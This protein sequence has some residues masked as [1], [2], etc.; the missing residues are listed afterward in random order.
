[1]RRLALGVGA[2]VLAPACG[3]DDYGGVPGASGTQI[4]WDFTLGAEPECLSRPVPVEDGSAVCRL[5][6]E[7][8][9]DAPC[10]EDAGWLDPLSG[11]TRKPRVVERDGV[12]HRI[13]EIRQ[14]EAA[15]LEG[16]RTTADCSG[17]EAGWC[18][19]E[20]AELLATCEGRHPFPVRFAMGSGDAASADAT[21]TC[22]RARADS[23]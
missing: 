12:E 3:G 1:M 8:T 10:P 15:A 7:L 6:V 22:I 17:C 5:L 4:S 14:L 11:S 9:D 20:R 13:C 19:T 23:P 21:L 16:C 18:V 2:L